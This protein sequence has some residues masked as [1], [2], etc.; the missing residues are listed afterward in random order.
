MPSKK[1]LS[2]F[3]PLVIYMYNVLTTDLLLSKTNNNVVK[4]NWS[5]VLNV[6]SVP[7]LHIQCSSYAYLSIET[8]PGGQS[9]PKE[10]SLCL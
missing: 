7:F 6:P 9:V 10:S 2:L 1:V 3:S 8:C 5:N 4:L